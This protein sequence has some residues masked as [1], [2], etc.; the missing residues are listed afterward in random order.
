MGTFPGILNGNIPT[1]NTSCQTWLL[2]GNVR[3]GLE[4]HVQNYIR[5]CPKPRIIYSFGQGLKRKLWLSVNNL[6]FFECGGRIY[7][8]F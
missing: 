6:T 2:L 5:K 4:E 7:K 8:N 3:G 1:H